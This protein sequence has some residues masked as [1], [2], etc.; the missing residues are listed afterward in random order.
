MPADPEKV[1][2]YIRWSTDD[3]SEGTTL[4]VQSEG[5]Q[6]Y[7]LSQGWRVR[8][9]L[10]FIDEGYSGGS[11]D[12]PAMTR[13]RSAVADGNVD[14]VV[15][16]KMDRLSRSVVDTV[17]LVLEEWDGRCHVKSA[18]E[19]IDTATPAGKLF[20]YM[21]VSYAEWERSLIR[22]RTFSGRLKRAQ[23]G[24]NP[25]F[26]A[27]YGYR[28][29][30]RAGSLEVVDD[31]AAIV[32]RMY[33]LYLAGAGMRT[34][35]TTLNQQ[36]LRFRQGRPWNDSTVRH[37]LSN[38]VYTGDLVWGLRPKN[39]SYGKR[40]GEK[41]RLK[42]TEPLAVREGAFP[43]IVERILWERVQSLRQG[44]PGPNRGGSGR[45][46]SSRFLLTGLARCRCGS[47]IIGRVGAGRSSHPY[48]ICAG[49]NSKGALH[50]D[51][52]YIAARQV[53]TIAAVELMR[54]FG[55]AAARERTADAMRSG[56]QQQLEML[57]PEQKRAQQQALRLEQQAR[58]LRRQYRENLLSLPE[59]RAFQADLDQEVQSVAAQQAQ[60]SRQIEETDQ[61]LRQQQ[62]LANTLAQVDEWESLTIPQQK[63]LL[64]TLCRSLVL[65][66]RPASAE[67]DFEAVWVQA[68][69]P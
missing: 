16:F 67:V 25:G 62:E 30:T 69:D 50:C 39:P 53:D 14:C 34:L 64:R 6:H 61:A 21:L 11:L 17:K 51:C 24:R 20:F 9:D 60:L 8:E 27:P 31:E 22:E 10:L 47:A 13:L 36:G 42:A 38:P 63:L 52:G 46:V 15:V 2:I 56:L 43:P 18:R 55:E 3:Q 48:Y 28:T 37:I 1:A 40:D 44:K 26:N 32:R 23:E 54:L 57:L 41:E 33:E 59:Y 68:Q 5:C 65:F 29:G 12:R 45:A 49:K 7:V 19:P 58:E 66:R 4:D 35:V